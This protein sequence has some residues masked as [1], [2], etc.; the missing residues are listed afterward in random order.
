MEITAWRLTCKLAAYEALHVPQDV[1]SDSQLQLI[2][3]EVSCKDQAGSAAL[4]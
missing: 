2:R 3:G 1:L 4:P